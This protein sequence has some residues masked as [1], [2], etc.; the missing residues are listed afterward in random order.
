MRWKLL[1]LFL[2]LLP[3]AF[4]YCPDDWRLNPCAK[5]STPPVECRKDYETRITLIDSG[6]S[7]MDT[8][9]NYGQG[10]YTYPNDQSYTVVLSSGEHS[11]WEGAIPKECPGEESVRRRVKLKIENPPCFPKLLNPDYV[12]GGPW[13]DEVRQNCECDPQTYNLDGYHS[14]GSCVDGGTRGGYTI[15]TE[16]CGTLLHYY[17][18]STGRTVQGHAE[19]CP[20]PLS[21]DYSAQEYS[22]EAME[23]I[24]GWTSTQY[25]NPPEGG[26][27]KQNC[28]SLWARPASDYDSDIYGACFYKFGNC[29][30]L[31]KGYATTTPFDDGYGKCE[32]IAEWDPESESYSRRA[33]YIFNDLDKKQG[34]CEGTLTD[35]EGNRIYVGGGNVWYSE[36][37]G[38]KR[39]CGDD[40]GGENYYDIGRYADWVGDRETWS[41]PAE[42]WTCFA[43]EKRESG[44]LT[45][46]CEPGDD[47]CDGLRYW[48]TYP[49]YCACLSSDGTQSLERKSLSTA[50]GSRV[51]AREGYSA[52]YIPLYHFETD[53]SRTS[54]LDDYAINQYSSW[55]LDVNDNLCYGGSALDMSD[56]R[57]PTFLNTIACNYDGWEITGGEFCPPAGSVTED[58]AL[59]PAGGTCHYW[60]LPWPEDY[61]HTRYYDCRADGCQISLDEEKESCPQPGEVAEDPFLGETLF[62][63]YVD[64]M[65]NTCDENEGWVC[66]GGNSKYIDFPRIK[67]D[68]CLA[69]VEYAN[70]SEDNCLSSCGVP[71]ADEECVKAC[72]RTYG[73]CKEAVGMGPETTRCLEDCE[74]QFDECEGT[75]NGERYDC[76][77]ECWKLSGTDRGVC[78]EDCN[79]ER[80]D[81]METICTPALESCKG[82]CED[83]LFD[84]GEAR[85]C[86]VQRDTCLAVDC[87]VDSSLFDCIDGCLDGCA[88][89]GW[90]YEE[91]APEERPREC[92]YLQQDRYRERKVLRYD[93]LAKNCTT[94]GWQCD[95]EDTFLDEYY[96]Y[97]YY[98][99]ETCEDCDQN[100]MCD[101]CEGDGACIEAGQDDDLPSEVYWKVVYENGSVASFGLKQDGGPVDG[102]PLQTDS[103]VI[104]ATVESCHCADGLDNDGDGGIDCCDMDCEDF[105]GCSGK[106]TIMP[107][108]YSACSDW[109]R[110]VNSQLWDSDQYCWESESRRESLLPKCDENGMLDPSWMSSV[111]E[112]R[113]WERQLME[114]CGF[115]WYQ[116]YV[117]PR[118]EALSPTWVDDDRNGVRD[119]CEAGDRDYDGCP[120][121]IDF[122][123]ESAC[124]I[125]RCVNGEIKC[126]GPLDIPNYQSIDRETHC[127]GLEGGSCD[128]KAGCNWEGCVLPDCK[129]IEEQTV[130]E[131]TSGCEW[132]SS[133]SN[134]MGGCGPVQCDKINDEYEEI[135]VWSASIDNRK[136]NACLSADGCAWGGRCVISNCY[137]LS[138]DKEKC[139]AAFG[140]EWDGSER[141]WFHRCQFVNC[142]EKRDETT[143][144]ETGLCRWMGGCQQEYCR[145][146]TEDECNA[147]FGCTWNGD[148]C[149]NLACRELSQEDCGESMVCSWNAGREKCEKI[150][151]W[152]FGEERLCNS[153]MGCMWN[154]AAETCG[155]ARCYY[156]TD[157]QNDCNEPASCS[158]NEDMAY[159]YR[160][161]IGECDQYAD[162]ETCQ[163][164]M[165]P[166]CEW[167]EELGCVD[168]DCSPHEETECGE[169]A[170]CRWDGVC[171]Y[172]DCESYGESECGGVEGCTWKGDCSFTLCKP[173]K[174]CEGTE[175]NF[176]VTYDGQGEEET[177]EHCQNL[178]SDGVNNDRDFKTVGGINYDLKDGCDPDCPNSGDPDGDGIPSS[179]YDAVMS[180]RVNCD[181]D[182]NADGC[183]DTETFTEDGSSGEASCN[184]PCSMCVSGVCRLR[185]ED[186]NSELEEEGYVCRRCDGEDDQPK[187]TTVAIGTNCDD[188]C[189]SCIQGECEPADLCEEAAQK[190]NEG[191][192]FFSGSSK[193]CDTRGGSC[194]SAD[195]SRDVCEFCMDGVWAGRYSGEEEGAPCCGDDGSEDN[196]VS[197]DFVCVRG[198]AC[199]LE[200]GEFF[201]DDGDGVFQPSKDECGCTPSQEMKKCNSI[202]GKRTWTGLCVGGDCCE[203][204]LVDF[205]GAR[206]CLPQ[207]RMRKE[208]KG[209]SC[210]DVSD[211]GYSPKEV[212]GGQND[213]MFGCCESEKCWDSK[214]EK[215][216]ESGTVDGE[217]LCEG[218]E[219]NVCG[220][221]N[222]FCGKVTIETPRMTK[223]FY[224]HA[225]GWSRQP[226]FCGERCPIG[227]CA[228]SDGDGNFE[229]MRSGN[230]NRPESLTCMDGDDCCSGACVDF[231]CAPTNNCDKLNLGTSCSV[232]DR[233]GKCGETE[234]G[235]VCC[236]PDKGEI[237]VDGRTCVSDL[238]EEHV[239]L[240]CDKVMG[241]K[242]SREFVS[243]SPSGELGCCYLQR[244]LT[245]EG[246]C[247]SGADGDLLCRDGEWKVC[248]ESLFCS[249][250]DGYYC[251]YMGWASRSIDA[252]GEGETGRC[253]DEECVRCSSDS[254]AEDALLVEEGMG[255]YLCTADGFL[256]CEAGQGQAIFD[257]SY[258][259]NDGS[260]YVC[261][262][263]E[264]PAGRGPRFEF[265]IE[266]LEGEEVVQSGSMY[267]EFACVGGRWK[268]CNE[269]REETTFSFDHGG[270]RKNAVCTSNNWLVCEEDSVF[271]NATSLLCGC[272][273][274]ERC[275]DFETQTG[276]LCQKERCCSGW[277]TGMGGC[278]ESQEEACNG[279][280][281]S[282]CDTLTD[283]RFQ[284]NGICAGTACCIN[285]GSS[286]RVVLG[287]RPAYVG[288][289]TC[290]STMREEHIGLFCDSEP[291][292][293]FEGR[294]GMI[295]GKVR[296]CEENEGCS[297]GEEAFEEE[298][299]PTLTS[300]TPLP[301][302]AIS[303]CGDCDDGDTCTDDYCEGGVC[304]HEDI[305]KDCGDGFCAPGECESCAEDCSPSECRDGKCDFTAGES[306]QDPDCVCE[307]S[308]ETPE[309]RSFELAEEKSLSVTVKNRGNFKEVFNVYAE[310]VKHKVEES[311]FSLEPGE[312]K[313]VDVDLL[314]EKPGSYLFE[315]KI[316]PDH[317]S[318]YTK[319]VL[320]V[321]KGEGEE[322]PFVTTPAFRFAVVV[323]VLIM[324]FGSAIFYGMEMFGS[325]KVPETGFSPYEKWTPARGD[326]YYPS[327]QPQQQSIDEEELR[328]QLREKSKKLVKEE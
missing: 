118:C 194:N 107:E 181:L 235:F 295:G 214:E 304:V 2:L 106:L 49:A 222:D 163:S 126:S 97:Y 322:G 265:S 231:T 151:C 192:P 195:E 93:C 111:S 46:C 321:I 83:V 303:V 255:Q 179:Y 188:E 175:D 294:V 17:C 185:T 315:V 283:G 203:E 120:D 273:N 161:S 57:S 45:D 162:K 3:L 308:Y 286:G 78:W 82:G 124:Q 261:T 96:S 207:G 52:D 221:E 319:S 269:A 109:R 144:E 32:F 40:A 135:Y 113:N 278:Y 141:W 11:W 41:A 320:A 249:E 250:L 318:E 54:D 72:S 37:S 306:C 205:G 198:E 131:D 313:K 70:E 282:I 237:L 5:V 61:N 259:C 310:G 157:D 121:D 217:Y 31:P 245:E 257:E 156:H 302:E 28:W 139:E 149:E 264:L 317:G 326:Y 145:D 48:E 108:R 64:A 271:Y 169:I 291:D 253:I 104:S 252:C 68:V 140:C 136:K 307:F 327:E 288:T 228:D 284:T 268:E 26:D 62:G 127:D 170:G 242:Q 155:Y 35:D 191:K 166:R 309:D 229:C 183:L 79:D 173:T 122:D 225:D 103:D 204:I 24:L 81:C 276:G 34:L 137:H 47:D 263:Q 177:Y 279:K 165:V 39:C 27:F 241:T 240:S 312:E 75:C 58:G 43:A 123:P 18:A 42:G 94:E 290:T 215:C 115:K 213:V 187:K 297:F 186:D 110:D 53:I 274:N 206:E 171:E 143:C 197:R 267:G 22:K 84:E 76:V 8:D 227:Y 89:N 260:W 298:P 254:D 90:M 36:G 300:S 73:E 323:F 262:E 301:E 60:G 272:A 25:C 168:V 112:C 223:I 138:D 234:D 59:D 174:K 164:S 232:S 280:A 201:V 293:T 66:V 189:H 129:E 51:Y 212:K 9:V 33:E 100:Y 220:D 172:P 86:R 117:L 95:S 314:E 74:S 99:C 13:D 328:R 285:D 246:E 200:A 19:T 146:Q 289:E 50:I 105:E 21:D 193:L 258:L 277:T 305:C 67:N 281:G 15:P 182:D 224:C 238:S 130:C 292:G 199:G 236:D 210:D 202:N 85:S 184:S 230:R 159:C 38:E 23:C 88:A 10:T 148:R 30:G 92:K 325:K 160:T 102:A 44:I 299:L 196:F 316:K 133:W 153:V 211:G 208:Q 226:A 16:V 154:E 266:M 14:E 324:G 158:W 150:N 12:T 176:C 275:I 216:V 114:D 247:R 4:S 55:I 218:G 296:C 87:K 239:G 91:Y 142:H 167:N 63:C 56:P 119:M 20:A 233:S 152:D 65:Y 101:N 1:L 71:N 209:S 134:G 77:D 287:S 190:C 98:E 311:I 251:N 219:W 243:I 256:H 116:E 244:C 6:D 69:Y 180:R 132:R 80:D 178:C 128:E 125:D 147:I 248:N 270:A 7:C 29:W